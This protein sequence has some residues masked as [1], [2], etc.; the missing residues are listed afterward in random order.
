[1]SI[2]AT[3]EAGR[4]APRARAVDAYL[5]MRREHREPILARFVHEFRIILPLAALGILVAGLVWPLVYDS[6]TGFRLH[7]APVSEPRKVYSSM[8]NPR[9]A[10][11]DSSER[12]YVITADRAD[13]I[14]RMEKIYDLVAPKGDIVDGKGH[15]VFTQG[16]TGRLYHETRQLD[17]TGDVV[18]F[19]DNGNRLEGERARVDL[20]TGDIASDRTVHGFGP[21]GTVTAEGMHVSR[22]GR[23]IRFTGR[24]HL[25][26]DGDKAGGTSRDG[27][28][29]GGR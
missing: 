23:L 10:G 24:T 16:K 26:I 5:G 20:L 9:F 22:Q 15:W 19:H 1:M 11:L 21:S 18:M 17:L 14:A 12:P 29:A 6:A 2:A 27:E 25:L 4:R 7:S 13:Q 8:D 28:K 3:P